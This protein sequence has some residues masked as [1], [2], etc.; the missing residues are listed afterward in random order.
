MGWRSYI[1]PFH[2]TEE[3]DKII[4]AIKEHNECKEY[5][6]VEAIKFRKEAYPGD[7]KLPENYKDCEAGEVLVCLEKVT[8]KNSKKQAIVCAN[9]GGAGYT[10][11]FFERRKIKIFPYSYFE[12]LVNKEKKEKIVL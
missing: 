5:I 6:G 1:L 11:N 2:S 3:Y 9:Q 12:D 4:E 8:Y 7:E 10:L